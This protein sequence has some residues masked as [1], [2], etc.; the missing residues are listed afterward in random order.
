VRPIFIIMGIN[1]PG[2]DGL[3][4]TG[5]I[6]APEADGDRSRVPDAGCTTYFEKPTDPLTIVDKIHA[7]L[8]LEE[9]NATVG[10]EH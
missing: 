8:G 3:E 1:L 2:I 7:L 5:R 9:N 6:G 4:A 10:E